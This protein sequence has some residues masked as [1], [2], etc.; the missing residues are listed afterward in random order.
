MQG[1]LVAQ[2]GP[3]VLPHPKTR[4][5]SCR[6][7]LKWTSFQQEARTS[8]SSSSLCLCRFL[9]RRVANACFM[10]AIFVLGRTIS[11]WMIPECDEKIETCKHTVV[12][13]VF[14]LQ[15][16]EDSYAR[17]LC[18]MINKQGSCEGRLTG[19]ESVFFLCFKFVA[20]V[21]R[22]CDK[23]KPFWL[24]AKKNQC[25]VGGYITTKKM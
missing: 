4:R 1:W 23:A 12:L 11:Q 15:H 22:G 9:V 7:P 13:W 24:F 2:V 20:Q 8:G 10:G 14:H 5:S 19:T 21:A 17:M 16:G 6:K 3:H 18:N 25:D